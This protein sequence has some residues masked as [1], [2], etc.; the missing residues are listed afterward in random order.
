MKTHVTDELWAV[1]EPLLPRH[2]PSPAGGRPRRNDREALDVILFVLRTGVQWA[3]IHRS[4][5]PVSGSTAWRRL[6]EW[7][8]A[9][10]WAAL[11]EVLLA[12][13]EGA[14]RIEWSRAS[15]DSGIVRA[16]GGGQKTGRSPV[17]RG[18]PGSKHHVIVDRQGLPLAPPMLTP[19]NQSD[20]P[21]LPAM[22]DRIRGVRGRRGRPR[23]R[24]KKVHADKGYDSHA[25][26]VACRL[27]G[28]VPR[29][30][31]RKIERADRLGR[32]RWV[33]ER[34]IAWLHSFRR[35]LV[36]YDRLAHVHEAFLTLAS[37]LICWRFV[38]QGF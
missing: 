11:M 25:N 22:L 23:R 20:S 6:T 1:I 16:K 4:L 2:D 36:R 26:R 33:V 18:R 8:E 5:F 31:R 3:E 13:L 32:H 38:E 9:G 34:T 15:V 19:A 10:V 21:T 35:L 24:S 12:R 27:R 17:D 37:A 30:A 14:G 7:Q 29:I 28:V